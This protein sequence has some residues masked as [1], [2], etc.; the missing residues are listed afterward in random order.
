MDDTHESVTKARSYYDSGDAD[1]FYYQ[2]WGGEDIHIGLYRVEGEPIAEASR[3]T[4]AEMAQRL[5]HLPKGAHVLDLGA[6]YGGS[7]RYLARELGLRVTALNLSQVQNDR[8]IEM[9]RQQGLD[10]LVDV[11]T[12]DFEDLPFEDDSFDAIWSQDS[13]LHS[14]RREKVFQE[15]DRVLRPGGVVCF[16]DPMMKEG[17]PK[18]VLQPVLDRIHLSSMGSVEAY[19]EYAGKLGWEEV[20]IVE[21]TGD[22][23]N[24]YSRVRAELESREEE[25]LKTCSKDYLERM[26]AGLGHWVEAGS[27]G[28]LF[29]GILTFRKKA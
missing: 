27:K 11:V 13:F 18:E 8:N 7:A 26:K 5:T 3:R 23:V 29:W 6:G 16:T 1:N 24:H 2:I 25:L 4:V 14:G 12:G 17:T 20:E 19:R 22:L 15:A 9:T 28:A 21:M 10:D